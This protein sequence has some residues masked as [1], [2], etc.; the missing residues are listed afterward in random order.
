MNV[1]KITYITKLLISSILVISISTMPVYVNADADSN[2]EAITEH[3]QVLAKLLSEVTVLN[4]VVFLEKQIAANSYKIGAN[5]EEI[6]KH[7][8]MLEVLLN[9]VDVLTSIVQSLYIDVKIEKNQREI[10]RHTMQ[11]NMILSELEALNDICVAYTGGNLIECSDGQVFN[12][13][14]TGSNIQKSGDINYT[15]TFNNAHLDVIDICGLTPEAETQSGV[16]QGTGITITEVSTGVIKF[17]VDKSV[18]SGTQWSGVLNG[19]RFKSKVNQK[20]LIS[21]EIN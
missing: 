21:V 14:F 16:I 20:T 11:L 13:V 2:T 1:N 5:L 3:S 18:M 12:L 10:D 6:K 15:V 7:E 17:T 19:I 9:E 8:D 4:K